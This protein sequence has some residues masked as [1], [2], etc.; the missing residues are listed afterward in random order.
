MIK[1][2]LTPI[3]PPVDR[4]RDCNNCGACCK[5]KTILP[6]DEEDYKQISKSN[7]LKEIL[8]YGHNW[9][10]RRLRKKAID[11]ILSSSICYGPYG[12][13][14]VMKQLHK[15]EGL[16]IREE[17]CGYLDENNRCTDYAKRPTICSSVAV[18]SYACS[19]FRDI[20]LA[21]KQSI[22]S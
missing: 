1:L 4:P 16:Y 18:G 21:H 2:E 7:N 20:A 15:G 8:E 10:S 13:E 14:Q 6:L 19:E 11:L 5:G 22:N 9:N 12:P 17:T 3:K